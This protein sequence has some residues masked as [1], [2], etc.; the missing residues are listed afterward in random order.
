LA[1]FEDN[2]DREHLPSELRLSEAR[3]RGQIPRSADLAA[4]AALLGGVGM[5]WLLGGGL[6]ADLAGMMAS[7]L[8]T[9]AMTAG[10]VTGAESF[11]G[12]AAAIRVAVLLGGT[13]V[14]A[15]LAGLA[16]TRGGWWPGRLQ[17]DLGRLSPARRVKDVLSRRA[18]VRTGLLLAKAAAVAGVVWLSARE[19]G[20]DTLSAV[21]RGRPEQML[22]A[23]GAAAGVLALRIGGVLLALGGLDYLHQ[24]WQHRQDLRTG[25]REMEQDQKR[26]EGD[27]H[28]RQRR[29]KLAEQLLG[30]KPELAATAALVIASGRAVAVALEYRDGMRSPRVLVRGTR[31]VAERILDAAGDRARIVQRPK[32][33]AAL[34]RRVRE[35]REIPPAFHEQVA[36][37]LADSAKR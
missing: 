7:F 34:Y 15:A 28:T 25:P 32:L 36:E 2:A 11:S 22:S 12:A 8:S 4:A 37:L 30:P 29:R 26:L 3:Q 9:P 18:G 1:L 14:L 19:R 23:A 17:P 31:R 33:A 6:V 27:A 21:T 16:Q 10:D 13:A 20:M 5:L 35:G 24:W